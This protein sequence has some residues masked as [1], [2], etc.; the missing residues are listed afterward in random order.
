VGTVILDQY[1]KL[2]PLID[3]NGFDRLER[4]YAIQQTD[5]WT[6]TVSVSTRTRV[7][8]MPD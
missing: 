5:A 7:I 6:E 4:Q 1:S 8:S 3:R 2:C